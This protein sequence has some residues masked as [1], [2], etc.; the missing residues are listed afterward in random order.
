MDIYN[1]HYNLNDAFNAIPYGKQYADLLPFFSVFLS[2]FLLILGVSLILALVTYIFNAIGLYTMA[3]KRNFDH[4]WLAFIPTA[5][6]Y[7]LGG[8]INDQVSVGSFHIP[9]AKIFLTLLSF[10]SAL[11]IAIFGMIPYL[12][13]VLTVLIALALAFYYY[14]GLFQLFSLYDDK[15]RIAFLVLSIFFPFLKGIFI[16]VIRNKEA[17]DQRT[18]FKDLPL[19]SAK[20]IIGLSLG[21]ISIVGALP[22]M[23][24]SLFVG[25]LGLIFSILALKELEGQAHGIA[26]AGLICSIAGLVLTLIFLVACV[27]CIG[28][29]GLGVFSQMMYS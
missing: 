20:S 8:L 17:H 1:Y 24:S 18:D 23:G 9:Y 4:P 22:L 14:A 12:G 16:F 29:G 11:I 7:I 26:L 6:N 28:I 13:S 2:V 5:N 19:V 15:H 27:A 10:G 3:K 21:I 25:S